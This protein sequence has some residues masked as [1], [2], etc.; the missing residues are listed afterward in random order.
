MT[1]RFQL[2]FFSSQFRLIVVHV[3][4]KAATAQIYQIHKLSRFNA[5]PTHKWVNVNNDKTS[6]KENLTPLSMIRTLSVF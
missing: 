4:Y 3:Q 1:S 5:F 2:T 6:I